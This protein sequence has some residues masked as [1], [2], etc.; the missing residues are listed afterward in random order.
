MAKTLNAP[1][2]RQLWRNECLEK[3]MKLSGSEEEGAFAASGAREEVASE[4]AEPPLHM[5]DVLCFDLS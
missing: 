1:I 3:V 4:I 2:G 5:N